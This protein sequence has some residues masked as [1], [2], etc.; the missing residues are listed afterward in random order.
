M[1]SF[2]QSSTL[3][4]F[5]LHL[6]K[7]GLCEEILLLWGSLKG[8]ERSSRGGC[9][10]IQNKPEQFDRTTGSVCIDCC[11]FQKSPASQT[12]LLHFLC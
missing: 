7:Q 9:S 6:E 4:I 12:T 11:F 2:Q 1:F 3:L 10:F 5:V 8:N